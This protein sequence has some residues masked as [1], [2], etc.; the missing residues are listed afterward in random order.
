[1]K[2]Q[3]QIMMSDECKS[4]ALIKLDGLVSLYSNFFGKLKT[5]FQLFVSNSDNFLCSTLSLC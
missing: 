2:S 1:M 5:S 3:L 4:E